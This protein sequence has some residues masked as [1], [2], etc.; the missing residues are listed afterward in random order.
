MNK[1]LV[2]KHNTIVTPTLAID[3]YEC[4]SAALVGVLVK[5]NHDAS[6]CMVGCS[7]YALPGQRDGNT[8]AFFDETL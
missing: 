8:L 5:D 6:D 3:V 4:G 7:G 2:A 1:P